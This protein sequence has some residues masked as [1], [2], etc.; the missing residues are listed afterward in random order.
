MSHTSTIKSVKILDLQAL[1]QACEELKRTQG[2]DLTLIENHVPRA[3]SQGQ[4]KAADLC[5]QLNDGEYDVG[6]YKTTDGSY[7]A[8]CDFYTGDVEKQLGANREQLS[9]HTNL[10]GEE[11]TQAQLGKLYQFYSV[12]AAENAIIR[13]GG[14]CQRQTQQ[15]GTIQL[16]MVMQAA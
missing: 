5:I 7:E 3:Y 6:L 2:V 12:K 1:R 15:D 4:L 10:T 8:R 16:V 13:K 11:R 9:L 14:S